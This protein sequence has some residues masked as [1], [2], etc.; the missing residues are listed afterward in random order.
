MTMYGKAF[1][2]NKYIKLYEGIMVCNHANY[3]RLYLCI[4][5]LSPTKYNPKT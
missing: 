1:N 4:K 3:I 5:V 2:H